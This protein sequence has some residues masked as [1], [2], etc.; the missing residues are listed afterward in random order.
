MASFCKQC[1]IDIFGEDSGDLEGLSTEADTRGGLYAVVLCEDCGPAL[2]D[3]T[4]TCIAPDCLKNHGASMTVE[5]YI[6]AD[7]QWPHPLRVAHAKMQRGKAAS[8]DEA[9][10]WAAVL[11]ANDKKDVS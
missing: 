7:R 5:Q 4:G 1:A 6:K 11:R 2:V 9:A 3:H 10:F 8:K